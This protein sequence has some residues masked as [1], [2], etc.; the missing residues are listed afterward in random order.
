[1]SG[2]ESENERERK[3]VSAFLA[4]FINL[5]DELTSCMNVKTLSHKN[6]YSA[7]LEYSI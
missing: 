6:E 7:S 2:S 5:D 1:M 4:F 3:K